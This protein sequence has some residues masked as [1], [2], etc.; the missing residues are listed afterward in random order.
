M[1]TQQE[2]QQQYQSETQ[3]ANGWREYYERA[4]AQ[5]DELLMQEVTDGKQTA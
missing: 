3:P 2:I 1:Y 5:I 4:F